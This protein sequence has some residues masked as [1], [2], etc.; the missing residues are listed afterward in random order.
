MYEKIK[1]FI[2]NDITYE[3]LQEV[4]KDQALENAGPLVNAYYYLFHGYYTKAVELIGSAKMTMAGSELA[5]GVS[6]M[7]FG[8][9]DLIFLRAWMNILDSCEDGACCGGCGS[10]ASTGCTIF[11]VLACCTVCME[12]AGME[13]TCCWNCGSSLQECCCDML[14]NCVEGCLGGCCGC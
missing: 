13:G 12:T 5:K 1:A 11:C 6:I 14:N 3:E 4:I 2:E 9:E 8:C 7:F 10:C